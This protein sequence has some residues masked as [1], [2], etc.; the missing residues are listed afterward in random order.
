MA[1]KSAAVPFW[2]TS[3]EN[4]NRTQMEIIATS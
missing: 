1:M 3:Q 2:E 4:A